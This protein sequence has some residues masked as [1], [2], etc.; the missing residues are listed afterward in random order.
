MFREMRRGKQL[1]PQETVVEIF[2]A[3]I[4]LGADV[5]NYPESAE[6]WKLYAQVQQSGN[7]VCMIVLPEAYVIPKNVFAQ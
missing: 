5:T 1:L 3:R 4:D 7:F 6:G 2:K